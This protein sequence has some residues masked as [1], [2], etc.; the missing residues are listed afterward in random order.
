MSFQKLVLYVH[1]SSHI[2]F[3]SE[4]KPETG[5]L[6]TGEVPSEACEGGDPVTLT[7]SQ[8]GKGNQSYLGKVGRDMPE[9]KES[10]FSKVFV[11]FFG[12]GGKSGNFPT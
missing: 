8:L 5:K 7:S 4:W 2:S 11:V 6:V 3:F 10:R 12:H 1:P 9:S